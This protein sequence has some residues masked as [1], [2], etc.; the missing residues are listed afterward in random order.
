[1]IFLDFDFL[2]FNV[3]D[4]GFWILKEPLNFFQ[5]FCYEKKKHFQD[6]SIQ[7]VIKFTSS[8]VDPPA[9]IYMGKDKFENEKLIRW[10]WPEDVWFHVDKYSSAHVY[11]RLQEGQS[12]DDVSKDLIIDCAQLVKA[13]S[14]EGCKLN[15]IDVVYTMSANLKKTGEMVVGQIGFYK[16][17]EVKK[18]RLEKKLPEIVK[19]LDKTRIEVENYDYQGEREERDSRIRTKEREAARKRIKA[20]EAERLRIEREKDEKSYDRVFATANMKT[21]KDMAEGSDDDFM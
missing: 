4:F 11:L 3:L 21:N 17:R 18:I 1:L 10:A 20:E 12:L 6:T 13:N 16:E 8:I 19:R 5:V 7:M 2:D 14:I 15:D 9:L